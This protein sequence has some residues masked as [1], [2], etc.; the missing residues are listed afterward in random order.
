MKLEPCPFCGSD[1]TKITNMPLVDDCPTCDEWFVI[2]EDYKFSFCPSCGC[3]A[4][5]EKKMIYKVWVRLEAEYDDIE[6]DSEDEAFVIASDAAISGG[7]WNCTI[8][9]QEEEEDC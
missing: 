3:E 4:K 1:V 6:A 8:E 7:S 2:S 5:G 9:K